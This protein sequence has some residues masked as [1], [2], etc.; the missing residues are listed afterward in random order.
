MRDK[1]QHPSCPL[2]TK[3]SRGT[4]FSTLKNAGINDPE[5][6]EKCNNTENLI[7][8]EKEKSLKINENKV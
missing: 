7:K 3:L 4:Q 1:V 5:G 8:G 6:L 2:S